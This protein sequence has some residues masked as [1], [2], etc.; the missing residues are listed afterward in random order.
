M[1]GELILI[2]EDNERSRKLARDLLEVKGYK[3]IESESAEG[4]LELGHSRS[5]AL[6]LMDIQ[7]PWIASRL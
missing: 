3:T 4:G 2:I 5:P 6:I 7:L 1:A